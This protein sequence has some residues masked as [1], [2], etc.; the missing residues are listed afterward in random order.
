M[1]CVCEERN[2]PSTTPLYPTHDSSV[3]GLITQIPYICPMRCIF[4]EKR[5]YNCKY[6]SK[7][8]FPSQLAH[9]LGA[10]IFPFSQ[11]G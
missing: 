6:Q 1:S 3:V 10:Y 4:V 5:M 11:M 9:E 2:D 8:I 7:L